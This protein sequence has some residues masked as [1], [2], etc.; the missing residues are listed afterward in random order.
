MSANKNVSV[1]LVGTSWWA[2]A[3]YLPALANH[4]NGR[5]TAICG[6]NAENARL[7]AERWNIPHVYTDYNEM[8][9]KEPLQALIVSTL[10]DT[11]YP[12]TVRAIEAGLHVL[13]EKP[14]GLSYAQ[15]RDMAVLADRKGIKHMTAFTY[16]F[17][18]TTR[19]IKEPV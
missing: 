3:M 11:H 19:Y 13:C 10:N 6:R 7:M 16:R 1:G 2:D 18:A 15:A 4:P 5:I 14:I 17:M 8:I 9:E 12:I